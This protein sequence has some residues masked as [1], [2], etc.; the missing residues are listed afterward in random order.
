MIP[1]IYFDTPFRIF[2]IISEAKSNLRLRNRRNIWLYNSKSWKSMSWS[3]RILSIICSSRS[4][5]FNVVQPSNFPDLYG[6]WLPQWSES[7]TQVYPADGSA[8]YCEFL[9]GMTGTDRNPHVSGV[10]LNNSG[11]QPEVYQISKP[12]SFLHGSRHNKT[13]NQSI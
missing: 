8:N 1:S 11:S 2:R 6:K 7:L 4:W 13:L 9:Q 5:W 12:Q 3:F 10:K